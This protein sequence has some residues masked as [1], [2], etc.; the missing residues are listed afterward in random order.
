[1]PPSPSRRAPA[2][3]PNIT[4]LR[5][6]LDYGDLHLIRCSTFSD[7]VRAYRKKFITSNGTSGPDLYDWRDPEHQAGLKEMTRAY[8]DRDKNGL[9]FWPDDPS[10]A[11]FNKLQ[12]SEDRQL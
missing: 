10:A 12:Y 2:T 9:L 6:A 3:L 8:L 11:N 1:M 7:D 5:Q 4:E